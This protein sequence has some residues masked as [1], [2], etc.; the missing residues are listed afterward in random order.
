[1]RRLTV[2]SIKKEALEQ[3]EVDSQHLTGHFFV[4]TKKHTRF[5]TEVLKNIFTTH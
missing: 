2:M 1:M 5:V 4:Q 3:V